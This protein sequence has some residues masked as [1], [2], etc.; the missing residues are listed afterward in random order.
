MN[1]VLVTFDSLRK[2][3]LGTYGMEPPWGK[4][5]TPQ[6]DRFAH[7]ALV[8]DRVFPEVLPTLP[9]RRAIYTGQRVYPFVD[10][11]YHFK[12]DEVYAPGWGPIFENQSTLAE[13]LRHH[14]NYRTGLV[15][16]L[17]H[18]FKPSKNFALGFDQWTF[19][20]GQELDPY[21]SGPDPTREEIDFWLSPDLQGGAE[22]GVEFIRRCLRNMSGRI[23]EQD[24]FNARIMTEA[25]HWLEENREQEKFFLTV[26]CFDPHEPWFV[27]EYYRR[28]YDDSDGGEHVISIYDEVASMPADLLRRAQANYS[29]LTTMCDRW[30]GYFMRKLQTLR[31]LDD[32]IVIVLSD[33]GHSI[34][35]GGYM[36][37]RGYPS[38]P[39]VFEAVL[40]IRHPDGIGA[41]QHSEL[42]L[43]HTDVSAQILDFAG[44]KPSQPLDG[45]PFWEK[46]LSPESK[47]LRDHVTVGWGDAMTVIHERW[48]LN[49]KVDGT[50]PIL[51]DLSK[52]TPFSVNH[53][54]AQPEIVKDLF[55]RGVADAG[56]EFPEYLLK[57]ANGEID[58][59]RW[60][61]LALRP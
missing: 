10:G 20:R 21:R 44:I 52:E 4:V 19:L 43:Q 25:A 58:V 18:M 12:G 34:G 14:A 39:E 13:I 53:A 17:Y 5:H 41:D 38:R 26:E 55:S 61:P 33:H 24:Y 40:M 22:Y 9:A 1:I 35:D 30:F 49:C 54:E 47:P 11:D 37:K 51:H 59:P 3:C 6:L 29:G 2:D 15:S 60:N 46:A 48:W 32:T 27:P 16:D 45:N 8:F 42:L 36:G 7:E 57:Q 31:L 56:G 28:M 23:Y 50:G